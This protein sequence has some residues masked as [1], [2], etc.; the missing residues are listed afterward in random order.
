[1]F[2]AVGAQEEAEQ[3]YRHVLSVSMGPTWYK[4]DQFGLLTTGLRHLPLTD[5]ATLSLPK[6]AGFLER[7]SG[8]LTFQRFARYAKSELI[9]ELCRRDLH[10]LA[11]RYFQR[12]SCGSPDELLQDVGLGVA[13]RISPRIGSRHPGGAIEE[14]HSILSVVNN[15]LTADW[16]LRF[17]LLQVFLCGDKRHLTDYAA[18]FA[19]AIKREADGVVSTAMRERLNLI[20]A[21]DVSQSERPEFQAEIDSILGETTRSEPQSKE[22]Q[23]QE[24][25][26]EISSEDRE[27]FVVPGLF[28]RQSA[29]QAAEAK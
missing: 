24:R 29:T 17:A 27:A 4:E 21:T 19:N 7:A 28:G 15:S 5:A 3:I 22:D 2:A 16:R 13:D 23:G 6:V 20:S 25:V 9:G 1:M 12:Q 10:G 18:A 14:Q 26:P 8:E 11:R